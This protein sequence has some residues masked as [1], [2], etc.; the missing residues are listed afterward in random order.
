MTERSIQ[1]EKANFNC[2]N[3]VLYAVY[4]VFSYQRI[5]TSSEYVIFECRRN[6]SVSI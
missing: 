4:S 6:E 5:G 3:F 1:N 2:A